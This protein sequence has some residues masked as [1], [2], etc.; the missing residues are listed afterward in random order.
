MGEANVIG[1]L[2]LGAPHTIIFM[3]VHCKS[4]VF[5]RTWVKRMKLDSYTHGRNIMFGT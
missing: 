4:T 1:W 2:C 3:F 5:G